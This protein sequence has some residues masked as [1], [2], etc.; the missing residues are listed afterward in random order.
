MI[1]QIIG[2]L[3][4]G[5]KVDSGMSHEETLAEQRKLAKQNTEQ[6]LVAAQ[7]TFMKTCA[8]NVKDAAG[9]Q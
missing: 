9:R 7:C 2:S 8:Q 6:M 3:L 4:G 5:N 1:G